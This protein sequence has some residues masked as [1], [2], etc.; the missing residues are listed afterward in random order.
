MVRNLSHLEAFYWVARLGNFHAAAERLAVTQPTVSVRLRTLERA[1]GATLIERN[2]S[3]A[4]LTPQGVMLFDFVER[5]MTLMSDMQEQLRPGRRLR[6]RLRLGVSDGFALL[7]LAD[8]MK[9]V[10]HAHPELEV[11]VR[12]GNS[13]VLAGRVLRQELDLAILSPSQATARLVTESLGLQEIAWVGS[14][15]L[16]LEPSVTP[17]DLVRQ[18]IFTDP[19]PSHLFAVLTDWFAQVGVQPPRLVQCDSVAVIATLVAAGAGISLLPVCLVDAGLAAG[20]V[21]LLDVTPKPHPQPIAAAYAPSADR[22]G[23]RQ[24]IQIVRAII[25]NTRFLGQTTSG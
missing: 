4:R 14:P 19:A 8:F 16:G 13:R 24:I 6:G 12:V 9:V 20:S 2:A 18:Q 22:A 5:I 23:M 15:E 17:A 21:R 1:A 25:N 11:A 3:G 7:C 10:R